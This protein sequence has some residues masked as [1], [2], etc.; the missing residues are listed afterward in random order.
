MTV[1]KAAPIAG[2]PC[3]LLRARLVGLLVWTVDAVTS[4]RYYDATKW[5]VQ[6]AQGV[7]VRFPLN[8]PQMRAG[9]KGNYG[10]LR[11]VY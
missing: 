1:A 9:D 10:V 3:L 2:L 4:H 11:H 8:A 7:R 6:Q 5:Q